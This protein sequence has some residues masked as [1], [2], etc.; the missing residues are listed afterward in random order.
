MPF[1]KVKDLN[2]NN[3]II[4]YGE[5]D[6]FWVPNDKIKNIRV[7]NNVKNFFIVF[8]HKKYYDNITVL[9]ICDKDQIINNDICNLCLYNK[10]IKIYMTEVLPLDYYYRP[11]Q[12]KTKLWIL[13]PYKYTDVFEKFDLIQSKVNKDYDIKDYIFIVKRHNNRYTLNYDNNHLLEHNFISAN[14]DYWINYIKT[15]YYNDIIF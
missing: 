7:I 10:A 6:L 11:L 9:K 14:E 12:L 2:D 1:T 13:P 8:M 15:N 5:H 4:N 3:D